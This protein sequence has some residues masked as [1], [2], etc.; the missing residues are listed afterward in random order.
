[1]NKHGLETKWTK[2][3]QRY[4]DPLSKAEWR[5]RQRNLPFAERI[6]ILE[7][8]RRRDALIAKAGLRRPRP[9]SDAG[10][11]PVER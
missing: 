9:E 3:Q 10:S 2:F 4:L 5:E 11:P 6:A 7:K 1:V 8:M